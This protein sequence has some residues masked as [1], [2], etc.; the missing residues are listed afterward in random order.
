MHTT[1][2]LREKYNSSYLKALFLTTFD[3]RKLDGI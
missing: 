3:S 2:F 1:K